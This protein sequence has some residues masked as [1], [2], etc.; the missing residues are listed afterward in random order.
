MIHL[1]L[2]TGKDSKEPLSTEQVEAKLQAHMQKVKTK[3]VQDAKN[4]NL[5][6]YLNPAMINVQQFKVQ[7][8]KRKLL[9]SAKKKEVCVYFH[10]I[11]NRI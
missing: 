9:W 11:L 5:P 1:I 6:S 10:G 3:A 8:E 4:I 2:I 7:Q